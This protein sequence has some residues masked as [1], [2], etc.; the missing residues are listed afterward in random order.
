M[1]WRNHS[2]RVSEFVLLGFPAPVPLQVLLFALLLLAYV[3][4][5]TENTLVIM[6]VRNHSTLHKLTYFF[7]ANMSF[8]E[9]WYVTV[10]IPEM[11]AGFVRSNR[12]MN[13]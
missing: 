8:L 10:T 5:L 11:L 12:I 7:L 2:G 4:V 3:L 1:E 9:I 6:A 13:G